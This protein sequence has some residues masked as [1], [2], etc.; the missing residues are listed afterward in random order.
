[1]ITQAVPNCDS[2]LP[3][4]DW[5]L[6]P[7]RMRLI[8]A[9][10]LFAESARYRIA[11]C[12]ILQT[13]YKPGK[14][15]LVSY[16][17]KI[18]DAETGE[19]FTQMLCARIY[20]PEASRS[21]F[22]KT[23]PHPAAPAPFKASVIHLPALEMIVWLFPCE[24]KL[25]GLPQ[26][27]DAGLLEREILLPV[28]A[29]NFGAEWG[30]AELSTEIVHYVA[31]HTCM[32]RAQVRLQNE[33]TGEQRHETLF[34]KTYYNDDGARSFHTMRQCVEQKWRV[35]FARPLA[36]QAEIRT[37]W[38]LGLAG[39]SLH[40]ERKS[41]R[42][43]RS[44]RPQL[45]KAGAALAAFHQIP[46][47]G[48]PRQSEAECLARLDR[49]DQMVAIAR[50]AHAQRVGELIEAIKC[51]RPALRT[52]ATLHGDLH[53]KNFFLSNGE[54]AMID[55]D[56]VHVGDPH[57]ELGSFLA[58]LYFQELLNGRR[59]DAA[60]ADGQVFVNA[61]V[62][63]IPWTIE[64]GA[65]EWATAYALLSERVYRLIT[66]CKHDDAS[67]LERLLDC[68]EELIART[69]FSSEAPQDGVAEP[70]FMERNQPQWNLSISSGR[71]A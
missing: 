6:N 33:R 41:G 20:P 65:L 18:I 34:G 27:A 55:L 69:L 68:A 35:A 7:A 51:G 37:L 62:E 17:I 14:N 23:F 48:I 63:W 49:L 3:Q 44:F 13:R 50:P 30:I 8:F 9:E 39:H 22:A 1:M 29:A 21:R 28:I 57:L 60:R 25:T 61:Y 71:R 19:G 32:L 40:E 70:T 66:R 45:R 31:E 36:Y 52:V 26:L 4:L 54:I 64:Q 42:I 10:A 2:M 12:E 24:R 11:E 56:N 5:V 15:C 67:I 46:V 16:G 43:G 58:S 38:Q 59:L 53:L 47:D